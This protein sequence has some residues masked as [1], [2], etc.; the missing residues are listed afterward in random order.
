ME[1]GIQDGGGGREEGKIT[2]KALDNLNSET[3][4][5]LIYISDSKYWKS[6]Y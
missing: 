2:K 5:F 3:R 1:I 6:H 4:I